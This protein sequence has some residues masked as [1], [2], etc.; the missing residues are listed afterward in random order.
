[1]EKKWKTE[2]EALKGSHKSRAA[3]DPQERGGIP[4]GQEGIHCSQRARDWRNRVCVCVAQQS[5]ALVSVLHDL[6]LVLLHGLKSILYTSIE[7]DEY[8]RGAAFVAYF[9]PLD[10]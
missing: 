9:T 5:E 7:T 4:E 3:W 1:M 10:H 6:K 8:G 2:L